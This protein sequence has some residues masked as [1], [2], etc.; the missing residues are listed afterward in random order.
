MKHHGLKTIKALKVAIHVALFLAFILLSAFALKDLLSDK[1]IIYISQDYKDLALPSFTTCLYSYTSSKGPGQ[2]MFDKN[3]LTSTNSNII[4][5]MKWV[6]FDTLHLKYSSGTYDTVNSEQYY[7]KQSYCRPCMGMT[8]GFCIP[9][10]SWNSLSS[11]NNIE[12]IWVG[13]SVSFIS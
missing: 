9:C 12:Q 11:I 4:Y 8:Q 10:I 3:S 13:Q 6:S 1:T 7:E 2:G 5:D